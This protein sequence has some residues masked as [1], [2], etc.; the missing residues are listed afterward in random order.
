MEREDDAGAEPKAGAGV[1]VI[2]DTGGA[3]GLKFDIVGCPEGFIEFIPA[4]RFVF[5]IRPEEGKDGNE[6]LVIDDVAPPVRSVGV[7]LGA[8]AMP[9]ILSPVEL[10]AIFVYSRQL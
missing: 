4:V 8:G 2:G 7:F 5:V 3:D 10:I 6:S 1:L 9:G